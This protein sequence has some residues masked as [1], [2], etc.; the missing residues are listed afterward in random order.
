[1]FNDAELGPDTTLLCEGEVVTLD[2]TVPFGTYVWQ[3]GST[4][5]TFNVSTSG[6]YAVTATNDCEVVTD[7]VEIIYQM[8]VP[9]ISLGTDQTLCPGEVLTLD[10]FSDLAS[11][12][13]QDGSTGSSFTVNSP[14]LYTVEVTNACGTVTDE[15]QID[16]IAP[17][18]LDLGPRSSS[19]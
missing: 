16:Y 11:Y 13:W 9:Q 2:V 14:G 10:A 4:D 5:P 7:A 8:D 18:Q 15:V 12:V 17:I 6:I 19:L 3:D 1:M